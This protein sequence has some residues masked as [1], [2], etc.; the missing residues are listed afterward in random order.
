[1]RYLD[2]ELGKQRVIDLVTEIYE[3]DKVALSDDERAISEQ[4]SRLF[5]FWC[6]LF[7]GHLKKDGVCL[8]CG[9]EFNRVM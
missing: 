3:S 9:K 6:W 7:Y 5:K 8:R 1:M 2:T 4:H